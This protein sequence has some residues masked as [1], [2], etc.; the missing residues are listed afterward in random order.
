MSSEE[1]K[2]KILKAA[3]E[4]F[5]HNGFAAANV[6]DIA[7]SANIN[8]ALIYRYFQSKESLLHSVL[9]QFV[10]DAAQIKKEF[11]ADRTFPTTD[12]EL[13][14]LAEWA[15]EFLQERHDLIR[16]ILFELLN[17][18]DQLDMIY[19]FFD[20]ILVEYL[21]P[22]LT[23]RNNDQAI[24]L[25]LTSFFYGLLPFLMVIA[26]GN[27][28]AAHYQIPEKDLKSHFIVSFNRLF[29]H[30]LMDVLRD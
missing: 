10:T 27:Q 3:T 28:W 29:A 26:I 12:E 5:A 21:P 22:E 16:V 9:D 14:Y 2:S 15:W 23:D 11:F 20:S 25:G 7:D 1:T 8:V 17:D 18:E 24:L 6:A 4:V 19:K 30:H 13:L